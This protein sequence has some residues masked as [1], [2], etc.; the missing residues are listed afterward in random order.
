MRVSPFHRV[1]AAEFVS[2][3]GSMLSRLAIPWLAA[4]GLHATPLQMG[5]LLMADVAAGAAGAMLLGTLVDRWRKRTVMLCTDVARAALLMLL[6]GLAHAGQVTF[7]MLAVAAAAGGLLTVA[8][9]LARSAWMAQRIAADQLS[10]GNAQLS[11]G[12]TLSETVAFA[13]GGWLYQ[14]AGAVLAL[15]VDAASYLASALCL[16]GIDHAPAVRSEPAAQ[17]VAGWRQIAAEAH[18]GLR[19]IAHD[20]SLRALAVTQLLSSVGMGIAG[21]SYMIFV[22]RD[23]A[24]GTGTLGL[25]FATGALG[26]VAAG[27]LSPA[28]G[29]RFGS[30]RAMAIGLALLALGNGLL[31]LAEIAGL[32]AAAL[33]IGQQVIG[34]GGH[35]VHDIHDRTLRQTLVSADRLARVD[36]G[37]RT[38]GHVGIVAGALGG[39]W[40]AGTFGAR[41]ALAASAVAYAMAALLAA[42][43]WW[44]HR[45]RP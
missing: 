32:L 22:S 10:T 36:A 43:R 33:L 31:P 21:T 19:T 41:W 15:A 26:A 11:I 5:W 40:F 25:I 44:W 17:A 18:D 39:G 23:L 24:F 8:F 42:R 4:L 37:I 1:L 35:T 3:F 12:T 38:V 45:P 27:A 16:R 6:A 7:W 13:L 14:G 29:R 30:G 20:G 28:L 34:D 9:E 2:N